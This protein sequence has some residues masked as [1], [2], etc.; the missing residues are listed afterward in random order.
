MATTEMN[1]KMPPDCVF[2]LGFNKHV[3]HHELWNG[4]R[5]A[6]YA[7]EQW[8]R[9]QFIVQKKEEYIERKFSKIKKGHASPDCEL[10]KKND[11]I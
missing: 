4:N 3:Y 10:S 8:R 2:T 5:R 7:N 11:F 6:Y 1:I 9:L